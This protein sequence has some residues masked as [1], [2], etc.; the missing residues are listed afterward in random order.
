MTDGYYSSKKTDD[1]CEDV[2]GQVL[3]IFFI[4]LF[5]FF[6]S[7]PCGVLLVLIYCFVDYGRNRFNLIYLFIFFFWCGSL[8][9]FCM[10]LCE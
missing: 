5:I 6:E 10:K 7:F 2:C 3:F 1:I 4:Y 9:N 8:L